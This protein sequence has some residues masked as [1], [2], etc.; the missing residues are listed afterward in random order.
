M[1][2]SAKQILLSE[3]MLVEDLSYDGAEQLLS[4]SVLAE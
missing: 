4:R 2:R 3:M 1:L